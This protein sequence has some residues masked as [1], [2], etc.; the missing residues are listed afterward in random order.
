MVDIGELN[1]DFRK[2][3]QDMYKGRGKEDPSVTTRLTRLEGDVEQIK[4][5]STE[6]RWLEWS[7]FIGVI[8]G[9]AQHWI[10]K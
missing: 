7:I 9:L 10:G 5:S 1:R 2:L 4:K 3:E 8:V 6:R